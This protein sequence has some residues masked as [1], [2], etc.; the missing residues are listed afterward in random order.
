M[1][2]FVLK[3]EDVTVEDLLAGAERI[4]KLAEQEALEAEKN[5]TISQNVVNLIK[6]TQI[7][8]MMLPKKY[9]G[10]QAD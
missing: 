6:E 1:A 5:A 3:G 2:S 10:P 7:S 8:R 4:G 9:G